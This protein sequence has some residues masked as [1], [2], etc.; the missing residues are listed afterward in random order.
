[1]PRFQASSSEYAILPL[2]ILNGYAKSLIRSQTPG[3][4]GILPA[5]FL[6]VEHQPATEG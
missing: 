1:M 5:R 4:A 3:S 6:A 2:P